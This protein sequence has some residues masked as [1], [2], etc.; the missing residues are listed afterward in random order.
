MCQGGIFA[1][2]PCHGRRIILLSA[3]QWPYYGSEARRRLAL[4]PHD[5]R[6]TAAQLCCQ[7][8][9]EVDRFVAGSLHQAVGQLINRRLGRGPHDMG[10][11]PRNPIRNLWTTGRPLRLAI[12]GRRQ[13]GLGAGD[14]AFAAR[15]GREA[16]DGRQER[17][18][19]ALVRSDMTKGPC[20]HAAT[21]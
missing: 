16:K 19:V 10:V 18:P 17:R 21:R 6:A 9:Q 12:D 4:R 8:R 13:F 20:R 14:R 11:P 15:C 3:G 7:F 5:L 2:I 1:V